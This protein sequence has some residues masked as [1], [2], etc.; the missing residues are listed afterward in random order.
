MPPPLL[1]NQSRLF[2]DFD[3]GAEDADVAEA[4]AE[5]TAQVFVEVAE[6]DV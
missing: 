2:H 5:A 3:E 4:E 6:A 1:E